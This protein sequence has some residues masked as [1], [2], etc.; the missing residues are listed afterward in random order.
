M[1]ANSGTAL[2]V[3]ALAGAI[4][5]LIYHRERLFPTLAL[6]AA[7]VELLMAMKILT[8]GVKGLPLALILG[9][10]LVVAG[11]VTWFRSSVK[12]AITGATATTLVGL[13][14]VLVALKILT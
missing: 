8:I 4:L 6:V 7:G 11:G 9:G 13:L 1:Q 5:A 12:L 3:A 10:I 2:V 14:Q